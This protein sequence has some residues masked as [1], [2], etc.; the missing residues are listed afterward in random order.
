VKSFTAIPPCEAEHEES[1]HDALVEGLGTMTLLLFLSAFSLVLLLAYAK[2]ASNARPRGRF[3][4]S[5]VWDVLPS[6]PARR[7]RVRERLVSAARSIGI[8]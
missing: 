5:L 8:L 6:T 1:E 2:G 7:I 4:R 3:A